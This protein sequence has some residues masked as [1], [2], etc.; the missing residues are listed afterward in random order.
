APA[1]VARAG[2][3]ETR[4]DWAFPHV[5]DSEVRSAIEEL[6]RALRLRGR[7]VLDFD[8]GAG[9]A[10]TEEEFLRMSDE[11]VAREIDRIRDAYRRMYP[12][13]PQ[14]APASSAGN[15]E[16][17]LRMSDADVERA[18]ARIRVAFRSVYPGAPDGA[19]ALQDASA[20]EDY[21]RMSDQDI[22]HAI[23]KIRRAFRRRAVS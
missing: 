5:P 19:D 17:F 21:L 2:A 13:A 7:E 6:R 1:P 23:E 22:E 3:D 10:G 16:D 14:P 18:I 15:D 4:N 11:D 20:E 8:L 9:E 12:P